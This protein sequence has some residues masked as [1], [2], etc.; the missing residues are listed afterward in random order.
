M[1]QEQQVE[2]GWFLPTTGDSRH[3][4]VPAE[5]EATASYLIQVAQA[6]EK[7][8]YAFALIPAGGD[9]LDGWTVG[10]WIAAHTNTLKPLIALRPGYV[11]PVP[12][13]RTAA[14]FDRLS[15]GR[16][17]LNVV[18]GHYE[19]DLKA[20][21]D[22][23]YDN[24]DARYE[25][26]REFLD[27]FQ[28]VWDSG[29]ESSPEGYHYQGRHYSV[30]GAVCRPRPV[31]TQPPLYFGGSSEVGKRVAA[32]HADVYLMWAE[33]LDWIRGQIEEMERYLDEAAADHGTRRTLRYGLRAQL[34]VRET[35]EE[36]WEAARE[37][38]RLAP[39]ELKLS[40]AE[41][42]RKSGAVNQR[43][44]M[45]LYEGSAG[46]DYV[47]GP[48]LW[49]GLTAVRGGGAVA[50]VGTPEQVADR[51][52]EFV[53]AGISSFILSGYPHLEEAEISGRLLLPLVQERLLARRNP[54]HETPPAA[55]L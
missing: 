19:A 11:A 55:R 15:Q 34:V 12:A 54:S 24:H 26:T 28:G 2:F 5:R 48:N 44:Q 31:Q 43:R 39:E 37:I 4:G 51:I 27:I 9:C 29:P 47:I 25:R 13:A 21:G 22:P 40:A 50:L 17:R 53:E 10:S 20:S 52:L 38:L 14:A 46:Q 18:T 23:L 8:G 36:A 35:E 3:I 32:R 45:E 7:A 6:A 30:E 33:P 1:S 16:L 49:A 42:Q 41:Y